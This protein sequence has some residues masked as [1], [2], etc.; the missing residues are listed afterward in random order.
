MFRSVPDADPLVEYVELFVDVGHVESM[1]IETEGQEKAEQKMVE[2]FPNTYPLYKKF[3]QNV[4]RETSR[5]EKGEGKFV[6]LISEMSAKET[7]ISK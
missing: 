1:L 4:E 6:K 7:E 3:I 2:A 5:W